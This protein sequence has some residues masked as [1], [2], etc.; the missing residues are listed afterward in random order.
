VTLEY[1]VTLTVYDKNGN[2]L[3]EKKLDGKEY[4]HSDSTSNAFKISTRE[5][6][7]AFKR[8]LEELLNN[9]GVARAVQ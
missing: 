9:P 6:P 5:S 1:D 3:A 8:K 2:R 4:L 7:R